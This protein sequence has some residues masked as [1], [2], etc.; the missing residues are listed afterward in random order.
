MKSFFV[1]TPIPYN[2]PIGWGASIE[3]GTP[4]SL[5]GIPISEFH[6][7]SDGL[8][9]FYSTVIGGSTPNVYNPFYVY[10]WQDNRGQDGGL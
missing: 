5:P 1:D 8:L 7:T 3:V 9:K 10:G 4:T 2:N 6:S